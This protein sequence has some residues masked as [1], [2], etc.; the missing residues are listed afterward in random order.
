M[1]LQGPLYHPTDV[2]HIK[3]ASH[4][5]QYIKLTFGWIFQQTGPEV[6]HGTSST[7]ITSCEIELTMTRHIVLERPAE[8]LDGNSITE[9][10]VVYM[11][12]QQKNHSS[13]GLS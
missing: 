4:L 13:S 6:Q 10:G 8:L 5:M 2:G 11:L 12:E 7:M 1:N 9:R 3:V